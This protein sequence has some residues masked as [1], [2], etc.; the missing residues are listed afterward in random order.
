ML[1]LVLYPYVYVLGRAAFLEQSRDTFEAARTLGLSHG[2]AVRR[3]ALPHGAAR[4]SRPA[5]RSR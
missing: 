4:R 3:V 1:T 2:G 5:R